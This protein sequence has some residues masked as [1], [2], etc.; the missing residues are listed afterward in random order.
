MPMCVAGFQGYLLAGIGKSLR[1][2][3][4]GKKA[5]LRK[6]ENSVCFSCHL[7]YAGDC[8]RVGLPNRCRYHQ[9]HWCTNHC[10]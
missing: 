8:S 7:K 1:L 3:E 5:L 2:Y 6:C 4:M 10:W 9:R